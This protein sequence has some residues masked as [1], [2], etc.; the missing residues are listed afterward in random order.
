MCEPVEAL[1]VFVSYTHDSPAHSKRVLDLSNALRHA[2]FDCDID[3]YH[4]NQ[5]WPAWMERAIESSKFVL[6]VCTSTYLRRWNNDEKPGAGLGA[7]WESL[8]TRQ[9]L[10]S[11]PGK[12]NK[13]VPVVFEVK[14]IQ[15]IPTP[16][17]DVTR[18]DLSQPDGFKRLRRRLLNIPPAEKPPVRTSLAPVSLADGF[19]TAQHSSAVHQEQ[20][21]FGLLDEPENLFSNLFPVS[22]PENIQTAH[23]PLKRKVKIADH[24]SCV[25]QKAGGV[26]DPPIDYWIEDKILYTFRPFNDQFWRSIIASKAIR[27]LGPKLTSTLANSKLMADKNIFIKLLNR[28]LDQLC[29]SHE[30]SHKLAWSKEMRCHLF[31]AAPGKKRGRIKVKAIAKHG[32][33]EVYKA[34]HDKFSSDPTAIQHWQH[35]AFRHFFV[36]FGG[37]WYLQVIPFWAFTSDGQGTPSRWQKSSSAN[38]RR[39]EKN[40][41]VLGHVAFWA[42]ILCR[43]DDLLRT[44]QLFQIHYPSKLSVS[45]SIS[46]RVWIG[47]TKA[48]DKTAL[49]ADLTLDV[50]L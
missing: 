50:L 18:I 44:N 31:L 13:F 22:F 48:A 45:P 17:G 36:R 40:R 41:A 26:G 10:Y 25:W 24:F 49:Q 12:N 39:P 20:H 19:F 15:C 47:I 6:V 34:I 32:Q 11:S 42:S 28:C 5:S 30:M 9:H 35:Q 23:V 46:D 3:Q 38:M 37:R 1:K 16:L 2:G 27:P 33:R 4:A 29:A 14:D 43:E 7:Q 21:P 8:L